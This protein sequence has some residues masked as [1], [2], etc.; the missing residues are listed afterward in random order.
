MFSGMGHGSAP[1]LH[2]PEG[3]APSPEE[4][5]L[6][7]TP[8][9]FIARMAR[10]FRALFAAALAL[11]LAATG[12]ET[13]SAYALK[14]LVDAVNAG[15]P[16][17][18]MA[19]AL[20]FVGATV[21]PMW[22][23]R[24][25]NYFFLTPAVAGLRA[26]AY[27]VLA[28]R[29]LE[30]NTRFFSSRFAGSL[31]SAVRRVADA[32]SSLADQLVWQYGNFA[33]KLLFTGGFLFSVSGWYAAALLALVSVLVALNVP[34]SSW[35]RRA[36]G[37][38]AKADNAL[39]GD[40]VDVVGNI[41][42]VRQF[43]RLRSEMEHMSRGIQSA[44]RKDVV[45]WNRL[46][47]MILVNVAVVTALLGVVAAFAVR[48]WMRGEMSGG[49]LAMIFSLFS[50]VSG[51]LVFLGSILSYTA[52][53]YGNVEE[54]LKEIL[55]AE[56][57]EEDTGEELHVREGRVSFNRVSF[58]YEERRSAGEEGKGARGFPASPHKQILRNFSLDIAG[59]EK[60]GVVGRTGAGKSTLVSLLLRE[61]EPVAGAICIDG[62]DI[63][64]VT[65]TSVRRAIA[66]VPQEPALFHRSLYENIAYGDPSASREEV[67]QAARQA[68][69]HD[70]IISL[71]EEYATVVGERGVKLSGGERQKIAIARALLKNAPILV[72]DEATSALDSKS[73]RDIQ[74]A[75]R[76]LMRGKTVIAIAHRL[77]T[78]RE[79]DRL[80]VL[81]GGAIVEEGS[82][83]ELC[84]LGG[85]YAALWRTQAGGF[86]REENVAS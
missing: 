77:S 12:L 78:L 58:Y 49:E 73:E 68:Q 28:A 40:V 59:G 62:V 13:A 83:E 25:R 17:S 75:L 48:G 54:G 44:R 29:L 61:Q 22:L 14:V 85:K 50:G 37:A 84:A 53:Y 42:T 31:A 15:A 67:E 38:F 81:E 11:E 1:V 79:M 24:A 18:V 39:A 57:R 43:V 20:G 51:A 69:I 6:P 10:P 46:N 74:E 47:A 26:E 66:V 34:L 7:A 19:A 32:A 65:L 16:K 9:R 36:S 64:T 3:R 27:R 41:R 72:L 4:A 45:Q 76:R 56:E 71:P 8:F 5:T 30:Q 60:V 21:G 82:H 52:S 80:V 86:L 63:R 33:V 23:W 70:Y 2:M 55:V 35:V